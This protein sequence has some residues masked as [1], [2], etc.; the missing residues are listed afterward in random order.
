MNRF[1]LVSACWLACGWPAFA[2]APATPTFNRDIAP[3]LFGKCA[4]CHRPGEVAPF[5]L[6]TFADAQKRAKQLVT[7][8]R[9]RLMP[10]WKAQPGHGEFLDERPVL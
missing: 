2:A 5:P 10:P 3:I 1:G 6:L 7:V 9:R 4:T 8:T